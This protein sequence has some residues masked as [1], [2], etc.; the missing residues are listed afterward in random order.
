MSSLIKYGARALW[1]GKQAA[2]MNESKNKLEATL[3]KLGITFRAMET[4][5]QRLNVLNETVLY[6]K[7]KSVPIRDRVDRMDDVITMIGLPYGM[8]MS[9]PE[10][11]EL[12]TS[13]SGLMQYW[14]AFQSLEYEY[15]NVVVDI[16]KLVQVNKQQENND[17]TVT[18]KTVEEWQE[19]SVHPY[20][21]LKMY[22]EEKDD[23][24]RIKIL[25]RNPRIP[26][27]TEKST[28]EAETRQFLDEFGEIVMIRTG[29]VVLAY[30]WFPQHLPNDQTLVI[31]GQMQQMMGMQ[32]PVMTPVQQLGANSPPPQRSSGEYAGRSVKQQ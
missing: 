30:C 15:A 20:L 6:V 31:Q 26:G 4:L 28:E 5:T 18:I 9:N 10:W 13:W 1:F 24:R 2:E 7:D 19:V 8:A 12:Y 22:M 3:Q 32:Q 17:G 16:R 29:L 14:L 27:D 21:A 23:D 25:S 11:A